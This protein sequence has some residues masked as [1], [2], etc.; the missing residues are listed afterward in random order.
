MHSAYYATEKLYYLICN[1]SDI[2]IHAIFLLKFALFSCFKQNSKAESFCSVYLVL[3]IY[4]KNVNLKC[5]RT[6]KTA[7]DKEKISNLNSGKAEF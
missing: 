7:D 1:V 5:H 6:S 2:R 4:L 3:G